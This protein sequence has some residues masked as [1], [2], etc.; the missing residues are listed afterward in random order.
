[1]EVK[2]EASSSLYSLVSENLD[3]C[4]VCYSNFADTIKVNFP[5]F[6]SMCSHCLL[7]YYNSFN[8]SFQ[9]SPL[10]CPV[11]G[12][13][14][15]IYKTLTSVLDHTDFCRFKARIKKFKLLT[16][17]NVI[18]CPTINCEGYGKVAIN[19][20][21]KCNYCNVELNRID[22]TENFQ[23]LSLVKCPGCK[24]WI[25][26]V[27]GCMIVKCYCGT[28]FC[29]K[30]LSIDMYSHCNWKCLGSHNKT[31]KINIWFILFCI[32]IYILL[33][34]LPVF[35]L[36]LYREF[37]DSE[38]LSCLMKYKKIFY[39]FFT[40]FSP[41]LLILSFF[42]LPWIWG[43]Y[44]ID[45]IFDFRSSKY[46]NIY[47]TGLKLIIYI[48]TIFFTFLGWLLLFSLTISFTPLYGLYLLGL[49]LFDI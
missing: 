21:T 35:T 48:P 17:H 3:Y 16:S 34:F 37:W 47:W 49:Y 15:E 40:V 2:H 30:C 38:Y 42:Y 36:V 28:E 25:S 4:I 31:E 23:G 22:D 27:F 1:M 39:V 9:I 46:K 5:C 24:A 29:T 44:C 13:Y 7:S 6:H 11:P 10:L 45:S 8:N 33:P 20:T 26:R 43:W 32:F 41:V 12:C 19:K 14:T 18:W